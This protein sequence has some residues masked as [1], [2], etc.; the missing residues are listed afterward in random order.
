MEASAQSPAAP[1][2]LG[3]TLERLT[4]VLAGAAALVYLSG[5][6]ALQLRLGAVR[7]PSSAAV[8]QLPREFLISQGLLIVVPAIAV[9][10]LSGWAARQIDR[11]RRISTFIAI[12]AG[13]VCYVAIGWLVISKDPFP[14]KVCLTEGDEVVGVFIGETSDRT[15]LGD[16]ASAHPRRVV[17]I[18]QSRVARVLIGGRERQ[19][20]EIARG[21]ARR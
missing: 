9:A 10:V 11:S 6:L 5:G 2:D 18:P 17:S 20:E 4:G 15:Y 12:V 8:S 14:A 13:L 7:L 16:L 21:A 3:A 1:R 19:L